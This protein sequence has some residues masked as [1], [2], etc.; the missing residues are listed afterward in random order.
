[1]DCPICRKKG[2]GDFTK[3]E[4]SC[5]QCDSD[6]SVYKHIQDLEGIK[7][8]KKKLAVP[9]MV[10]LVIIIAVAAVLV[11][12][13]KSAT[14]DLNASMIELQ[15]QLNDEQFKSDDLQSTVKVL[16][17][18]L[19]LPRFITYEIQKG[20][21]PWIIAKRFYGN[22]L[23]YKMIQEDNNLDQNSKFYPGLILK[24]RFE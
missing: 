21:N 22:P 10:I 12:S 3:E 6:L 20:D 24:I 5:P 16:R 23:K 8:G 2:I 1:M 4:T 11:N 18:S 15:S 13:E 17:D 9:S 19:S 7:S 14:K